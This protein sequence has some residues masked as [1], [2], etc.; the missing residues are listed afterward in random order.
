VARY[1]I[2]KR[3]KFLDITG[4]TPARAGKRMERRF[5]GLQGF[6]RINKW[7]QAIAFRKLPQR[8]NYRSLVRP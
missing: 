8:S 3:G 4:K 1:Y 2:L 5:S 7:S 6:A